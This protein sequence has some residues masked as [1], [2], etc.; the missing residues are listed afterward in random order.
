[1]PRLTGERTCACK[2]ALGPAL[3]TDMSTV[4]SSR[5]KELELLLKKY[6]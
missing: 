4:P 1:M 3:V 5:K 6:L 2:D